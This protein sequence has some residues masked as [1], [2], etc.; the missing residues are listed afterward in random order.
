MTEAIALDAR[1][2]AAGAR[3]EQSGLFALIGVAGALQFSIVV[4]QIL[5]AIAAVC[6]V[7]LL[8]VRSERSEAP[9]FFWPLVVYAAATL[10]SAAWSGDPRTSLMDSKQLVLFL[11]VPITYRLARGGNG[12]TLLT[13]VLSC[14]AVSAVF[15]IFQ[16]G[17]LHYDNLG[18]RP[19]GTLGHW[20][21][22]SGVLMIVIG[23][24]LARVLFG[25]GGRTWPALVIPALAVAVALTFTRSAEVGVC[26]AAALLFSLKDF[27]LFAIVPVVAA[28]FFA[29]APA[30]VS[31]R[32]VS[33]FDRKDPTVSDRVTMLHIGERM[34]RAHPL[35]GVGPNMVQRLYVEYRGQ[36]TLVGPDGVV[37]VNP[38]LHNN[39]LQIAAER[40]LPA[41]AIWLWFI[42]ALVEDLWA[43]F[44]RGE[45]RALAA[46]A[47][48]TVVSLLTAG[49][50][51]YNFG[52]SEVLMLF[53]IIVTLP[54]AAEAPG[55]SRA[56]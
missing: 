50:F 14:A 5:L 53:L 56:A 45:H 4:A 46:T 44:A 41:L 35:I 30:S 13:V 28:V 1:R 48:A 17:I 24:A 29:L 51:E 32:F 52:D 49:L 38:H 20:M 23:V 42:V 18:Q 16:Y 19:Q 21:T 7:A 36:D 47:L 12:S 31:Q 43:R 25:K 54:A 9:A 26:A 55:L 6:W 34:I 11:L 40:G 2:P 39:L 33:M 27:R 3:L 10:A 8:V 37:H 15:G 22:Y